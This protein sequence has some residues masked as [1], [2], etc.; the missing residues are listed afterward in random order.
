MGLPRLRHSDLISAIHTP[1][2]GIAS[3]GV[4]WDFTNL[5]QRANTQSATLRGIQYLGSPLEPDRFAAQEPSLGSIQTPLINPP[6]TLIFC[7]VIY[8]AP[9]EAR[10][11]TVRAISSTVP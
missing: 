4:A 2:A 9:S 1:V 5:F 10:N 6:S 3:P 8:P 7:P 11:A